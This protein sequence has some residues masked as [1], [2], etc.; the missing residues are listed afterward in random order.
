MQAGGGCIVACEMDA[1][2][3]FISFMD[4]GLTQS[5]YVMHEIAGAL[6]TPGNLGGA[7]PVQACAMFSS[8]QVAPV[9][10]CAVFSNAQVAPVHA[11]AVFSS[12][13]VTPVRTCALF[14]RENS[15]FLGPEARKL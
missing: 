1:E 9:H 14:S 5:C 10:A 2:S 15:S 12:A 11:C 8:A 4:P 13:Q 3:R 7:P 6:L